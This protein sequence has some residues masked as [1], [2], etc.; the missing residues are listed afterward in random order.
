MHTLPIIFYSQCA[1]NVHEL[2]ALIHLF[3]IVNNANYLA[4]KFLLSGIKWFDI[5]VL[6]ARSF[7]SIDVKIPFVRLNVVPFD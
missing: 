2:D 4:T 7:Y 1:L 6:M 5:L 3:I